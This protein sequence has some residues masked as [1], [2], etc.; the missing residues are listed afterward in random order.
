[1]KFGFDGKVISNIIKQ[2]PSPWTCSCDDR[3][4]VYVSLIGGNAANA[5]VLNE[6]T[7]HACLRRVSNSKV[8]RTREEIICYPSA[9]SITRGRFIGRELDVVNHPIGLQFAELLARY[10]FD[11]DAQ[12]ALHLTVRA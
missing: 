5:F 3:R 4:C 7:R 9:V 1:M 6:E 8:A 10:K 2:R 11:V 12:T